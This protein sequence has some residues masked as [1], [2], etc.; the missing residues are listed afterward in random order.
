MEVRHDRGVT[1]KITNQRKPSKIPF[2]PF[3]LRFHGHG[4]VAEG[5]D[6]LPAR[7]VLYQHP[8]LPDCSSR[9]LRLN[10][11]ERTLKNEKHE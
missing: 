10:L 4:S 9:E 7:L 11:K 8:R 5:P 2:L 1:N 6:S 3:G